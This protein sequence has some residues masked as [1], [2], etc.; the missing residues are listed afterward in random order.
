MAFVLLTEAYKKI[1]ANH[2]E[3]NRLL[4]EL[5]HFKA[6]ERGNISKI[7]AQIR[8][9]IENITIPGDITEAI[10]GYFNASGEPE[11]YAVKVQRHSGRSADGIVCRT[12]GHLPEHH[13][14]SGNP[15][16]YQQMLGLPVYGS[17]SY[18][19]PSKQV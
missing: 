18:L 10:T 12:T 19:P 9:T 14:D 2:Q 3:L 15:E 17:G 1:T 5:A 13:R 4:D 16:A 8:S 11:A 7:A 6:E